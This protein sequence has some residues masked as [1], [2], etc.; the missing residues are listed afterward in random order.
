[1]LAFLFGKKKKRSVKKS[2]K[3]PKAL[4][5][6]A[7]KYK[8]KVTVRRGSKKVYKPLRVI[9]KQIKMK[10]NS[11]R[12]VRVRRR[13]MRFG[14]SGS[15]FSK[16]NNNAHGYG[17]GPDALQHLGNS[18]YTGTVIPSALDNNNRP[19]RVRAGNEYIDTKL[20]PFRKVYGTGKTFFNQ[21]IPGPLPPNWQFMAQPPSSSDKFVALGSPFVT[22]NKPGFGKKRR[23]SRKVMR[24]SRNGVPGNLSGVLTGPKGG[25]ITF[26][27]TN[28]KKMTRK[29]KKG[30]KNVY[31]FKVKRR[32]G[33]SIFKVRGP[34]KKG[35]KVKI[36]LLKKLK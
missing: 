29:L 7:R 23:F 30:K 11:K 3:P 8:V 24:K 4:L 1:M 14:S 12:K 31:T 26:T 13:K 22:Y 25:S 9:M 28:G 5:K 2:T 16:D 17:P 36:V 32:M 35:K 34:L 6:M 33:G 20:K 10:K 15:Y 21:T 19:S 27:G 18:S